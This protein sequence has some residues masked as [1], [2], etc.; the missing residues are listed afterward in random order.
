MSLAERRR[1][2]RGM[3]ARLKRHDVH[4]WRKDF[5]TALQEPLVEA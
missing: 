2:W 1:R 3:M 5:L 4:N